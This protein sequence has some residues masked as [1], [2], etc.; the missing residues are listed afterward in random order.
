MPGVSFLGS[1]EA[2]D[3]PA[4]YDEVHFVWGLDFFEEGLNSRWLLPNRLYEGGA[5]DRPII[6]Q[7]GVETGRWLAQRGC[8]VLLHDVEA[9]LLRF[10]EGLT[11]AG[12]ADLVQRSAAVPRGDLIADAGDSRV[13]VDLATGRGK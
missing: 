12:Y 7:A 4:L 10:F 9:D 3:L 6:A 2:G 1:Y 11:A 13:M 5:R 8:G